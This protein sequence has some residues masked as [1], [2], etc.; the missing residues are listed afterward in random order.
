MLLVATL[1]QA[2]DRLPGHEKSHGYR[3]LSDTESSLLWEGDSSTHL[4]QSLCL[5][6]HGTVIKTRSENVP[7]PSEGVLIMGKKKIEE[8]KMWKSP[9]KTTPFSLRMVISR[10]A[11]TSHRCFHCAGN[12]FWQNG[13]EAVGGK[14]AS[15]P[16]R[17][18][19]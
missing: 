6:A 8:K 5:R 11:E 15:S 14:A 13:A 3:N 7:F 16:F 10:E 2:S 18:M 12:A 17:E 4:K 1:S 9:P 19:R